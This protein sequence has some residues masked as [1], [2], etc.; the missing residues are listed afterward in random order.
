VIAKT[1][2][3]VLPMRIFG[4]HDALPRGGRLRLRPITIVIGE[5]IYFTAADLEP[6]GKELYRKLSER[7]MQAIAALEMK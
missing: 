5:P 6:R 7:V 1:L 2:A 4:A 3:P